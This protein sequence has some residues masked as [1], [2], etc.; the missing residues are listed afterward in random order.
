M[1]GRYIFTPRLFD[2]LRDTTAGT[3]GEIQLTDA[4]AML[5]R[6]EP[7]YGVVIEGE[8]FDAG[9]PLGFLLANL[10]L[11]LRHPDYGEPLRQAILSLSKP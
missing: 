8:R 11:G 7:V 9:Q 5:A 10:E 3:G 6:D 2:C 4:M 1:I